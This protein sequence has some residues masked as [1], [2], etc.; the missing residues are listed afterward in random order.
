[1][2]L[3]SLLTVASWAGPTVI[4]L[5][6]CGLYLWERRQRLA[7]EALSASEADTSTANAEAATTAQSAVAGLELARA[8]GIVTAYQDAQAEARK[9]NDAKDAADRTNA[10]LARL[11]VVE[12]DDGN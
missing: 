8:K 1:M 5:A 6:A 12:D 4:A 7:A 11:R 10:G 3:S 2:D 9:R